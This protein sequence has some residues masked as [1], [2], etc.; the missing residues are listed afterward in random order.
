MSTAN[1]E[2]LIHEI[3]LLYRSGICVV[4]A[5]LLHFL[6]RTFSVQ[7]LQPAAVSARGYE[8]FLYG[9][10]ACRGKS[11]NVKAMSQTLTLRGHNRT[12]TCSLHCL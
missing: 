1:R 2:A 9:T 8:C 6:I 3:F 11:P 10:S 7:L 5:H 12:T 4:Y